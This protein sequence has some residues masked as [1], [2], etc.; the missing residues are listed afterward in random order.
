MATDETHQ[1]SDAQRNHRL[2]V[3][4]AMKVLSE[5]PSMSMQQV[6]DASGLGRTTVYRH[7]ANREALLEAVFFDLLERIRVNIETALANPGD[8]TQAI[9]TVVSSVF[10][11]GLEYGP[12][13]AQRDAE[14]EAF[15]VGFNARVAPTSIYLAGAQKRGE[16]RTDMPIS[17][18]L[19]VITSLTLGAIDEVAGG[20]LGEDEAKRL[21]TG[22][23]VSIVVPAA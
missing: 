14:S 1:R 19:S 2:V 7:F 3:E 8:P 6:A 16:I 23:F 18:L 5:D 17:W 9:T 11:V 20:T 22:T 15:A 4:A 13:I 21:V 12:L 10:D